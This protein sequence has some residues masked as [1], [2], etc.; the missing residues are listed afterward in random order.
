[1][2]LQEIIFFIKRIIQKIIC[3]HKIL[4]NDATEY[5][6][7]VEKDQLLSD[8]NSDLPFQLLTTDS[9]NSMEYPEKSVKISGFIKIIFFFYQTASIVR[10]N[11]ST[12]AQYHFPEI[13]DILLSFHNIRID[14]SSTYLLQ[15]CPIKNNG[16]ISVEIVKSGIMI[17][18]PLI[19]LFKILL[20]RVCKN[21]VSRICH[22]QKMTKNKANFKQYTTIDENVPYYGNLPFIVRVKIAYIQLLLIGFAS[23]AVLLFKMINCVEIQGHKY[24]YM[25]ATVPCYTVWQIFAMVFIAIWVAPFW[26][27]I[28]F[29]CSLLRTCKVTPN[30]YLFI[31]TFPLSVSYYLLRARFYNGHTSL[32]AKDAILAREFLR[33]VNEPF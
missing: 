17:L 20:Y 11:S 8:D 15:I 33:V 32:I 1:M 7:I 24:L 10:I 16:T 9:A 30:E 27:S 18:C 23:L 29:S 3:Y 6:E 31:T 19:L 25:Q 5:E 22:S 26:F 2:Y 12:K 13:A 14:I 4:S 28:Y 21:G